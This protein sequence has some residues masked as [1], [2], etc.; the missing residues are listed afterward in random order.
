MLYRTLL[1][2]L[3]VSAAA[4]QGPAAAAG[5]SP[6][7][8]MTRATRPV[9]DETIMQKALAGELEEEGAENVF[10]SELGWATYL[11]KQAGSSYNMNERVSQAT[12][13]YFTPSILSNPVDGAHSSNRTQFLLSPPLARNLLPPR[14]AVPASPLSAVKRVPIAQ[15]CRA[16]SALSRASLRT[17][18]RSASPRSPTT[19]LATALTRR[20]WAR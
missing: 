14:P 6:T 13:G 16:G 3:A 7:A 18:C 12:D 19:N 20:V 9:M 2:A 5:R 1:L 11:D 17:R 4:F 10:M 8:A 15:S